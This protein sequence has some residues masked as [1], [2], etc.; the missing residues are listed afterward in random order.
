MSDGQTVELEVS[1]EVTPQDAIKNMMDKWADGDLTGANDEF[2]AM[3]NKRADD[4]LAVRKADVVPQIF[5]D[6]EMQKM[7]L[8]S[9]PEELEDEATDEDV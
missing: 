2:F 6:P 5:N 9:A 4:M 1:D 3:M 8:E 7:G